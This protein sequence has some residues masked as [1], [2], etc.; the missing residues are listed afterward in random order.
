MSVKAYIL[1][2]TSIGL[3]YD[4]AEEI[5][6]LEDEN[7]KITVDVVFGEYDLVVTVEGKDLKDIDKLVTNV[8]RISGVT[9][10]VTL[11][12]SIFSRG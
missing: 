4:V 1:L 8:R 5:M 3:E 7:T 11:I 6:K 10:T 12:S 9:K 2:I